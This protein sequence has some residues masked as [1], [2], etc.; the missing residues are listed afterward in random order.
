MS[1]V[2]SLAAI[3]ALIAVTACT[4]RTSPLF[5]T[6]APRADAGLVAGD[7]GDG[8][9]NPVDSGMNPID[10]GMIGV[11]LGVLDTGVG[12]ECRL[13]G[14]YRQELRISESNE[15]FYDGPVTVLS[16][17]PF[18][19]QLRTGEAVRINVGAA[20][21]PTIVIPGLTLWLQFSSDSSQWSNAAV[22]LREV[23]RGGGPGRLGFVAWSFGGFEDPDFALEDIEISYQPESCAPSNLLGCGPA[24]TQQLSVGFDGQFYTVPAM[25]QVFTRSGSFA[26]GGSYRHLS[27][28]E[29]DDVPSYWYEGYVSLE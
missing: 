23:D 22:V 15:P 1:R 9:T 13:N 17:E 7:A 11:D 18:D 28:P 5:G 3:F 14:E 24:V 26:N 2:P 29:C 4:G 16:V 12:T 8:G 10:A 27:F 6:R 19:V 21:L 20:P 25:Q